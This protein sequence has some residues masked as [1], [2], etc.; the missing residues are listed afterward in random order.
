MK[1]LNVFCLFAV[2][3]FLSFSVYGQQMPERNV[4]ST[5]SCSLNDGVDMG[6]LVRWF[7]ANPRNPDS[8]NL[9]FIRQPL[10]ANS[11]FTDNY[12]F[13][14]ATY[15]G[16]YDEYISQREARRGGGGN[17][18]RVLPTPLPR[19]M[20]TCDFGALSVA[21]VRNIPDGDP[22]TGDD[23]LLTSRLCFLT[24]GRNVADAYNFVTGIAAGF[25][26]GGDNALM[27]VSTRAF[28][29]IQNATAGR[30]VVVSEVSSTADS[31][32]SRLDLTREGLNV[33]EGLENVMACNY[34]SLWRTHAVY[35]PDN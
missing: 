27:Q 1:I 33:A 8:T 28:G 13:R 12:D 19:D 6:E 34:P 31:M 11:T 18:P 25:S 2:S 21:L 10:V 17:E 3:F 5:V 26:R 35:R 29:P 32:A 4:M 22:F 20:F 15:Y 30:A 7:R 24:E 14:I 23:T 16:S 9:V